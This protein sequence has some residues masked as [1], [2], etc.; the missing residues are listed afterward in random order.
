MLL[1]EHGPRCK[2]AMGC[3]S[4][5]PKLG[6]I[7]V[8]TFVV[9]HDD[10]DDAKLPAG[11]RRPILAVPV[12]SRSRCFAVALYGP[13]AS[14]A[15]LDTNERTL[16]GRLGDSAADAYAALENAALRARIA[17]LEHELSKSPRV[18]K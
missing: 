10:V 12:A 17:T 16:L 7:T 1:D 11:L 15:D 13:H 14:G 2:S 9:T 5:T 8:I 18:E 3:A 4:G 6:L